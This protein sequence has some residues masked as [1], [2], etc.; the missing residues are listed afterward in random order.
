MNQPLGSFFW[1]GD[2]LQVVKM[3][4][5]QSTPTW[6]LSQN[7]RPWDGSENPL[8]QHQFHDPQTP[9]T[10][11]AAK[12]ESGDLFSERGCRIHRTETLRVGGVDGMWISTE[13]E[14]D[15]RCIHQRVGV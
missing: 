10:Q 11:A 2:Q 9:T 14:L 7:L 12:L 6:V 13:A 4:L 5:F 15:V 8:K 3:F 1:G